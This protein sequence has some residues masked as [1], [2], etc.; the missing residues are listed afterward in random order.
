MEVSQGENKTMESSWVQMTDKRSFQLEKE[1]RSEIQKA[2]ETV[3]CTLF[4]GSARNTERKYMRRYRSA[5][6]IFFGIEHMMRREDVEEQFNKAASRDGGLQPTQ[7]ESPKKM[8][9]VMVAS[10][11]RRSLCSNRQPS[12]SSHWQRRVSNHVDPRE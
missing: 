2:S 5:W 8:Q 7:R 1:N 9:A 12:G 6:D 11:R 4:D 3:R 10:T